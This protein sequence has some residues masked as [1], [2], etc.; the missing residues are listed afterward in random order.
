M[1][2]TVSTVTSHFFSANGMYDPDITGTGHQP[3]FFDQYMA[4]YD[5]YTVIGSRIRVT[6]SNPSTADIVPLAYGCI[7]DDNATFTY[8]TTDAIVESNQGRYFKLAGPHNAP[9]TAYSKSLTRKF[10]AKKF[11]GTKALIG[12][13]EYKGSAST[14]PSEEAYF[15]VW[16]GSIGNTDGGNLYLTCEIEYIAVLTEPKF[17]NQ[18]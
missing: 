7:I 12:Q 4:G 14:N 10:S 6:P 3:L 1:D 2:P 15:G 13:E 8:A 9:Q 18:S 5:H 17:V 16:V 11:F